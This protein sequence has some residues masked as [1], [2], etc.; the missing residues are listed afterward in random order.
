MA[1]AG[2]IA[3]ADPEP[4]VGLPAVAWLAITRYAAAAA[5]TAGRGAVRGALSATCRG[6]SLAQHGWLHR[7]GGR[8]DPAL[9]AGLRWRAPALR[10]KR[11]IVLA[12]Y[13]RSGNSL[14]RKLLEAATGVCTGTFAAPP[15][16]LHLTRRPARDTQAPTPGRTARSPGPS[17]GTACSGRGS[18][19]TAR[20][21]S[22]RTGPSGPATAGGKRGGAWRVKRTLLLPL[23][24]LLLLL[25]L[26]LLRPWATATTPA[27]P[28]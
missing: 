21:W 19:T 7:H 28:L 22:R 18:S 27:P 13:P 24:L 8:E 17:S 4:L 9:P 25:L 15:A 5:T 14:L 23:P 26:L 11:P 3:E 16:A 2:L 6:L 12:S 1:E 20:C 10:R